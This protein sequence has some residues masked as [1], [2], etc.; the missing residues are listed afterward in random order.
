MAKPLASGTTKLQ[1]QSQVA[2][3]CYW[4][5]QC[6]KIMASLESEDLATL[7]YISAWPQ[8]AELSRGSFLLD[9]VV[10]SS[11]PLSPLLPIAS[12]I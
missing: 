10:L 2:D 1:G 3:V 5:I 7:G 8:L 4:P 6:F 9:G 12:L 11:F